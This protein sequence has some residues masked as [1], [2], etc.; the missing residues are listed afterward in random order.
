MTPPFLILCPRFFLSASYATLRS[1]PLDAA[2][3]AA[4]PLVLLRARKSASQ[5]DKTVTLKRTTR[6]AAIEELINPKPL[7]AAKAVKAVK[8]VKTPKEV[9]AVK[10]V[11]EVKEV[12]EVKAKKNSVVEDEVKKPTTTAAAAEAEVSSQVRGTAF[13]HD[14]VRILE[15]WR[16]SVRRIGKAGDE[17]IDFRGSWHLNEGT[18]ALLSLSFLSFFLEK[19]HDFHAF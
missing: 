1:L 17:G 10:T 3:T 8:E 6:K 15:T 11:K 13:E 7:K 4:S 2:T 19:N 9:K 18:A 12:K 16:F 14:V 5:S